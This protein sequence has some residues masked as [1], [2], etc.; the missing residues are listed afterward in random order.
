MLSSSTC[1]SLRHT[2]IS[3]KALIIFFSSLFFQVFSFYSRVGILFSSVSLWCFWR[4]HDSRSLRAIKKVMIQLIC[5]TLRLLRMRCVVVGASEV[6]NLSINIK[7]LIW[8]FGRIMQDRKWGDMGYGYSFIV[9]A[10]A[11][12]NRCYPRG[13]RFSVFRGEKM[14][15][16]YAESLESSRNAKEIWYEKD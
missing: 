11:I 2:S 4:F 13:L 16:K 8:S 10:S 9:I 15:E 7:E 6:L 12:S 5:I 1:R 14:R 3:I